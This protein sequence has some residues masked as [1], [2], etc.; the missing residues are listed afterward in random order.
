MVV[1]KLNNTVNY[2]E[3]T[4]VSPDDT[5]EEF[6]VYEIQLDE[7]N[8]EIVVGHP[9]ATFSS[10]NITYFPIYLLKTDGHVIQIGVYEIKSSELLDCTDNGEVDVDKLGQPLLYSFVTKDF[11][12]KYQP[13]K[14]NGDD[15]G[16][17]EEKKDEKEEDEK[18]EEEK[19]EE[20]KNVAPETFKDAS[21]IR[22]KYHES[23]EDTWIQRFMRNKNF[24][25]VKSE[26]NKGDLFTAICDALEID[27]PQ[28][29][30]DMVAE[31]ITD[32]MFDNFM[33]QYEVYSKNIKEITARSIEL[34]AMHEKLKHEIVS[35]VD[36]DKQEIIKNKAKNIVEENAMLKKDI[37]LCKELQKEF[38][39]LK[40]IKSI[41]EFKKSIVE[42]VVKNEEWMIALLERLLNIKFI[43]LS[44]DY[45]DQGD[46]WNVLQCDAQTPID[47][48]IQDRGI[49]TPLKY[50]IFEKEGDQYSIIG[51]KEMVQMSFDQLPYDIKRMVTDKC[52]EK[53]AGV[54]SLIHNF[55]NFKNE[56]SVQNLKPLPGSLIN[57]MGDAKMLD[58]YDNQIVFSINDKSFPN[59]CPGKG[60][61]EMIS[62]IYATDFGKLHNI[63]HWRRKLDDTWEEPFTLDDHGWLSVE[64]YYQA[65]KFKRTNPELYMSF[66]ID[67]GSDLSNNVS[68]AKKVGGKYE[69]KADPDFY[70][71]RYKQEHQKALRA[72]FSQHPEL[73]EL[74][75]YTKNAKITKYIKGSPHE[76]QD[77]LMIV[78]KELQ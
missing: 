43:V 23:K 53:N 42:N 54:Y 60:A 40:K 1:S 56:N 15:N 59:K 49:F 65:S 11:V 62:P 3:L 61:A 75:S 7:R 68:E 29:L 35:T 67:S 5:Q 24:I 33:N 58:L 63:K 18:E 31:N 78:R 50:I 2:V 26:I 25:L 51:Y 38:K 66:S 22:E 47:M 71:E 37:T 77:N 44:K 41:E 76:T 9:Q 45:Y 14:P 57:H 69:T 4:G 13:N 70:D 20:K 55:N 39:Y 6:D 74:L 17:K 16:R 34:N 64:H 10:K 73:K 19:E 46:Y 48:V 12:E 27:S 52:F 8:V 72:K 21:D 32:E 36:S 30:R 28:S